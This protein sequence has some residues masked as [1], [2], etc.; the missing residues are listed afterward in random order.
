MDK[1]NFAQE[2]KCL[3]EEKALSQEELADIL[4]T[5]H[6]AFSGINQVMVSQWERGKTLPSFVRRLGIASFFQR[7]YEFSVDE[8]VHVKG[9]SKLMDTRFNIDI[10]YDYHITSVESTDVSALS[11]ER[12][13]SIKN[14]HQKL[15][16]Q[17]FIKVSSQLGIELANMKALCFLYNGVIIGHVIYDGASKMLCS[18]AAVSVTIRRKI[19]DDLANRF[20]G[21]EFRFPTIDPAMCQFLYDLYFEPYTTKMGMVFF[22][23]EITKVVSNPFSQTIQN[24]HDIYFKYLRYQ[25]LKQKKKSVEFVL[26]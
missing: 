15:Y 13:S 23:A 16:G 24:K 11:D 5:S 19:F 10:G 1:S 6:R 26:A 9:A 7:E 8:M 4:S 2:L 25:D 3:R 20:K 14:M 17:D 21:T 12:L 22:K 18:L